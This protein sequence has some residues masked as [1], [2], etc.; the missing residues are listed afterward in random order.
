LQAINAV[1]YNPL[2]AEPVGFTHTISREQ[3][4][5]AKTAAAYER[6]L[7]AVPHMSETCTDRSQL[8]CTT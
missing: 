5:A 1:Q 2:A 8:H 4:A 3:Q 7:K 6:F